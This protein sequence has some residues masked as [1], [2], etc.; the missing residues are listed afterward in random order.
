MVSEERHTHYFQ[1]KVV[2]QPHTGADLSL[3][4]DTLRVMPEKINSCTLTQENTYVW[5]SP[6]LTLQ[7]LPTIAP[8]PQWHNPSRISQP[9][10]PSAHSPPSPQPQS[11]IP[12]LPIAPPSASRQRPTS[13]H[14]VVPCLQPPLPTT[15][16]ATLPA[17]HAT[18]HCYL[19]L[20]ASPRHAKTRWHHTFPPACPTHGAP[21][22]PPCTSTSEA[23]PHGARP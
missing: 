20:P 15:H 7:P 9:Y 21:A 3:K 5:P 8:I 6:R 10:C 2:I 4:L 13:Q 1:D 19:Y 17:P 11:P 18:W 16:V 22:M 12:H 14:R 23:Q